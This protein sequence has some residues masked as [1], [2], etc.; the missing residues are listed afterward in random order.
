MFKLGLDIYFIPI[1]LLLIIMVCV[2]LNM[3]SRQQK[4]NKDLVDAIYKLI[5][6]TK[7]YESEKK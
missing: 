5:E 7:K 6:I 3:Q 4:H 1:I 2:L